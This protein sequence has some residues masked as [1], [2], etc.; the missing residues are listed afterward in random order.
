MLLCPKYGQRAAKAASSWQRKSSV[1]AKQPNDFTYSYELEGSIEDKL[2]ADRY[3]RSTAA[4]E[5]S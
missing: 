3:R 2:N 1:C 5:L 4:R